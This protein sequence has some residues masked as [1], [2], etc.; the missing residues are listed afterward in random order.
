[1]HEE[2]GSGFPLFH[3]K[4]AI[5]IHQILDYMRDQLR[6]RSY[7]LVITPHVFKA[8]VWK[9]SGHL[10]AYKEH[11]F[12]TKFQKELYGIKPMNCPGHVFIYK[13]TSHSYR[14]LPVRLAEFGVV[15]R[16]EL[17]GVIGGLTRV[18]SITQD[19]AHIFCTEKQIKQEVLGCM[20]FILDVYKDFGLKD[21]RIELSTRPKKSIGSK[22]NWALATKALQSA[23]D[24][25]KVKYD[26]NPGDGAFYGP[27]ID[28]HVKDLQGRS[29]QFGTI[30]VDFNLPERFKLSYVGDD[31][32]KHKPIMIHRTIL[33]S[34]ERFLGVLIEHYEGK[35]PL[36][37]API[38][39]RIINMNDALIPYAKK[40]ET[41]LEKHGLRIDSDYR[42]ES[43]QYKVRDAEMQ[44]INYI[45][46]VGEK[47]LKAKTI[48]VR[49]LGEKVQFGVKVP[50]FIKKAKKQ[51]AEKN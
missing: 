37:L 47:E 36:W 41:E 24:S 2:L 18:R 35:F 30:Q 32:K 7:D 14:D 44:K 45:L 13:T 16:L 38:Q 17:S 42:P 33:G 19:D 26:L 22:E 50:D 43:V 3:P 40:V 9:K 1:M 28:F 25:T 51:I 46:V 49:P 29:W 4:G 27:K 48:A 11:M 20:E 39:A 31:N 10:E 8:D 6:R 23:L 34:L 12:F 15:Y 21:V 5:I